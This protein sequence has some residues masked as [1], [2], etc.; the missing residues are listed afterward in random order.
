VKLKTGEA[1]PSEFAATKQLQEYQ[2]PD[3]WSG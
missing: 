2:K 1:A 3:L